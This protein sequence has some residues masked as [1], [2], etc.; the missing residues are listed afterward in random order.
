MAGKKSAA[1]VQAPAASGSATR[2]FRIYTVQPGD[3]L[4]KIC[5]NQTGGAGSLEKIAAMNGL[6]EPYTLHPG[7]TLRLPR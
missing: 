7:R 6:S 2:P 4:W 1:P 5:R 3:T